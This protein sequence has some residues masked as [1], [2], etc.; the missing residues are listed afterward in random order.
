MAG[1]VRLKIIGNEIIKTVGKYEPRMVSKLPIIF[2]RTRTIIEIHF[3]R[4]QYRF[5]SSAPYIVYLFN[6]FAHP[7]HILS[8]CFHAHVLLNILQLVTEQ[9]K[10]ISHACARAL[11]RSHRM[12]RDLQLSQVTGAPGATRRLAGMWNPAEPPNAERAYLG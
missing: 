3:L 9:N 10:K 6:A 2:T 7:I 12:P 8:C 11:W 1:T 5:S 4:V